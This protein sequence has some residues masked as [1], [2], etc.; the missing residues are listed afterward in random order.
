MTR[1]DVYSTHVRG[2]SRSLLNVE[3]V[4]NSVSFA[5]PES[6]RL[7][8]KADCELIDFSG[9]ER[10]MCQHLREFRLSSV[11]NNLVFLVE[12]FCLESRNIIVFKNNAYIFITIFISY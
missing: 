5:A 9:K 1:C 10:I 11:M 6:S 12:T 7:A 3:A 2:R 8:A 4:L